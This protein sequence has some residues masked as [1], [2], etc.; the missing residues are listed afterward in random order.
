MLAGALLWAPAGPAAAQSLAAQCLST[1]PAQA[2]SS[3]RRAFEADRS[4][5]RVA[6]KLAEALR[7]SGEAAEAV[8]VL[9][10]A[11]AA[12]AGGSALAH[13]LQVSRSY[14]EEQRFQEQQAQSRNDGGAAVQLQVA[15]IKCTTLSGRA[16]LAACDEALRLAP[17]DSE[18]R[19]AR[20]RL[21]AALGG[22]GTP[23]PAPASPAPSPAPQ[24]QVVVLPPPAG[25]GHQ[26]LGPKPP[27]PGSIPEPIA[28]APET[29]AEAEAAEA[30]P[31][32]P[33]EDPAPAAIPDQQP[34][35]QQ[36]PDQQPPDQQVVS[37]PETEAEPEAVREQ[38]PAAPDPA[39]QV[40]D[41]P[42]DPPETTPAAT[43]DAPPPADANTP[44]QADAPQNTPADG[45]PDADSI[46][47]KLEALKTLLVLG[48]ISREEFAARRTSILNAAFG[49]VT[50]RSGGSETAADTPDET[51]DEGPGVELATFSDIDFGTY[52]A[53][54]IGNQTYRELPDLGTAADDAKVLAEILETQYGFKVRLLLDV[55]RAEII[56]ALDAYRNS[57]G[58]ND[59]L[60]IYYAGHGWLDEGA[61]QGYWLPVN[62]HLDRR[63]HWVSNATIRDAVRALRAKHVLV[64]ADSCF[65]GTLTRSLTVPEA[66]TPAYLRRMASKR[67]RLAMSSG[68][69]EPV[70]DSVGDGHSPF[71]SAFISTLRDNTGVI[72]GTNLFAQ[73][74]RPVIL[75]TTQT[76]EYSDI[77]LAGHE[78]G[79]F[80]FVR[81][82]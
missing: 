10:Q 52:H 45:T 19:V 55:G 11:R 76:P 68:G 30:P 67:A 35:D 54:I 65:A 60:L 33:P 80:L 61:D 81:V 42:A 14:L 44:D 77:R 48:Q 70:A 32:P 50:D 63:T 26:A 4:D 49:D 75:N 24:P 7:Y 37:L 40:T 64:V 74:R 18:L 66:P 43:N 28:T 15:R 17:N 20:T 3:C 71:A 25:V 13:A 5:T 69:L 41:A 59:N 29:V 1:G 36:P 39:D 57:L 22:A 12:G 27:P 6:V 56:E 34:P 16:A 2:V 8:R 79:D 82:Q 73:L 21:R 23:S 38:A 72:D 58:P 53:L 31:A 9:E 78:G 47:Q 51:A 46:A 62:A